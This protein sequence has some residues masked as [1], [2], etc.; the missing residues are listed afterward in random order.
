MD[1]FSLKILKL[2]ISRGTLSLSQLSAIL[3]VD[4]LDIAETIKYLRDKDYLDI[5]PS[6]A[7]MENCGPDNLPRIHTPLVITF[8]GKIA[9]EQEETASKKYKHQELR[10][11]LTFAIALA[12]FIKS[13]F[14]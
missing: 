3:N 2:F 14:F 5:E 11:W 1:K 6:H 7:I 10:L 13:F 12:S 9:V 8:Q 4:V